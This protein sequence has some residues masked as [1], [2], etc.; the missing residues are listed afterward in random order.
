M[1]TRRL[2]LR[3]A[4]TILNGSRAAFP[5]VD[6]D[7]ATL[8]GGHLPVSSALLVIAADILAATNNYPAASD[9]YFRFKISP[10]R[11]T[12]RLLGQPIARET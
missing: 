2:C 4:Q 11:F 3:R 7:Q 1:P 5:G 8:I 9:N 10:K 6:V 12:G